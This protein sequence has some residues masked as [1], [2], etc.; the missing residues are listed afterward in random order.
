MG[1]PFAVVGEQDAPQAPAP[2][3]PEQQ[4]AQQQAL[5][6]LM[7]SL[8]VVGQRFVTALSNLFTAAA[9]ASAWFLWQSVLPNPTVNQLIG[10]TLYALFVG[11]IEWVRRK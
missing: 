11:G 3:S 8:K 7:L 5:K 2:P 4:A 6:I 9:L 10:V 1:K